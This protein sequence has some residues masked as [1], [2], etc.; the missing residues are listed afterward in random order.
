VIAG[1]RARD[2][3]LM[4]DSPEK[5][6]TVVADALLDAHRLYGDLLADLKEFAAS[7]P[8]E[9]DD[10]FIEIIQGTGVDVGMFLLSLARSVE[11]AVLAGAPPAVREAAGL[12]RTA[13]PLIDSLALLTV[14]GS[15]EELLALPLASAHEVDAL[16]A[17]EKAA[18]WIA[19]HLPA[20]S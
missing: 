13:R 19:R 18:A 11:E 17:G 6:C 7:T 2:F 8:G 4:A 20:G 1:V 16:F 9:A 3:L 14:A 15:R 10:R 12:L 5:L